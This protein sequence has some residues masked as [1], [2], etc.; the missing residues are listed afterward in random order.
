[1]ANPFVGYDRFG[2]FVEWY[3]D[4]DNNS[5]Q[6]DNPATVRWYGDTL[7]CRERA[8][9]PPP[10]DGWLPVGEDRGTPP[11]DAATATGMYDHW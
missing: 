6:G 4:D 8:K 5:G 7:E 3:R 10:E 11:H 2:S 9:L 1:M